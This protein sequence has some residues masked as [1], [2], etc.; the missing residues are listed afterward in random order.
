MQRCVP[1]GVLSTTIMPARRLSGIAAAAIVLTFA[2]AIRLAAQTAPPNPPQGAISGIVIDGATGRPIENAIVSMLNRTGAPLASSKRVLTDA[3]GRFVFKDLPPGDGYSVSATRA[4]Y[5]PADYARSELGGGPQR[6]T[7]RERQWIGNARITM[8]RPGAISGAVLDEH[9]EPIVGIYVRALALVTIAGAPHYAAISPTTTDDRGMYRIS[10]LRAGRYVVSVPVVQSSVPD[11]TTVRASMGLPGGSGSLSPFRSNQPV[12]LLDMEPGA[13]L[14]VSRYPMPV[15]VAGRQLAYRQTFH[16]ATSLIGAATAIVVAP[17]AD[18]RG[19]DIR[20][21]PLPVSRVSGRLDGLAEAIAG[22]TLR[23]LAEG[24]EDLGD[25]SETATAI[26]TPDGTFTF[27]HV[28]AGT[29]TIDVRRAVTQFDVRGDGT[30]PRPPSPLSGSSM[31][32]NSVASGPP[33][34]SIATYLSAADDVY[35]GRARITVGGQDVHGVAVSLQRGSRVAGRI[36]WEGTPPG[37]AFVQAGIEPANGSPA[38]GVRRVRIEQQSNVAFAFDGVQPGQYFLRLS[39][40]TWAIKSVV[41]GGRDYAYV[42]LELTLGRD[43]NDVVVTMVEKGGGVAGTV[44]DRT[45]AAATAAAV[46]A[47]PAEREQWSNFGL[48]APRF[49]SAETST[50]AYSISGLPAGEYFVVAVDTTLAD[51]WQ[52]PK[53][54]ERAAALASRVAIVWDDTKTVELV[55]IEN[56]EKR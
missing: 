4:G 55:K 35:F 26:T 7:L 38:L 6:I 39:G 18:L 20:L 46:I 51:A 3:L 34:V 52:D 48:S 19:I 41:H 22:R 43:V 29:Y 5:L 1:G 21:D 40:T 28:P 27:V 23:L 44:R 15:P 12:D 13:R 54:L 17:G 16:P 10:G 33:D 24:L 45:G 53:F 2:V 25:G 14:A 47:F 32:S 37:G 42:P 49:K 11:G 8:W 56:T 31:N 50:G 36:V 9:G 30:L